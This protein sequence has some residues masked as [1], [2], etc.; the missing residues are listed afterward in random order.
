MER[1]DLLE[2]QLGHIF[3]TG[4][5]VEFI[6]KKANGQVQARTVL[7]KAVRQSV[8]T[9]SRYLEA[10][11]LGRKGMRRFSLENILGDLVPKDKPGLGYDHDEYEP[12]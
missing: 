6:Y 11:D 12:I 10:Y 9:G 2:E 8:K 3:V 1:N 5:A 4:G 7:P